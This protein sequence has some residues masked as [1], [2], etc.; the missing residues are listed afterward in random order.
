[1]RLAMRST[2]VVLL[3][4]GCVAAPHV[5]TEVRQVQSQSLGLAPDAQPFAAQWW[6]ELGD[7]QLDRLIEQGL[8]EN[9]SLVAALARVRRAEASVFW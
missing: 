6:K 3:L 9:P 2:F 5:Q 4:G 1:M 7:P 8:A